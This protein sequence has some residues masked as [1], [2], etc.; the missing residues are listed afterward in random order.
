MTQH[1][2]VPAEVWAR[3]PAENKKTIRDKKARVYFCDMV[4]IA[5]EVAS[6]GVESADLAGSTLVWRAW[7]GPELAGPGSAGPPFVVHVS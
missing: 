6:G 7:G 4:R 1:D 2:S 3:I 5:R